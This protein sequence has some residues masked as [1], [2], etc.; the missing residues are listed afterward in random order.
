MLIKGLRKQEPSFQDKRLPLTSDPSQPLHPFPT[1]RI[2]I[3]DGRPYP[4]MRVSVG[5]LRLPAM[6]RIRTYFIRLQSSPSPQPI[7]H[8]PPHKRLSYITLRRSKKDQLGIS[9][10][11]YIFRLNSYLSTYEPLTKYLSTRYAAHATPQHP[12]FLTETGKMATRFWFQK[13]FHNVLHISGIFSEHYSSHSFRIGAAS[14][15]ARLGISD[16]TIQVLG[17]WSSQAYHTYIRNN[18]NNLRQAHAQLS[19]I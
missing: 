6:L 9:F 19:S 1:L 10:P 8:I 17:R 18:L 12:L 3:T 14:T 7:R 16:Q 4:R 15:A 11:I 5:I 2:L 13:H